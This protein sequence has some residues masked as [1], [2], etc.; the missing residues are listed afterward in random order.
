MSDGFFQY[1][2]SETSVDDSAYEDFLVA[3]RDGLGH[4]KSKIDE[5]LDGADE[6]TFDSERVVT[7]FVGIRIAEQ[8]PGA[9]GRGKSGALALLGCACL[10][11][12]PLALIGLGEWKAFELLGGQ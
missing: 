8:D 5:I 7:D 2:Y 11:L 4:L 9:M 1:G 3:D 6:V 12:I 10:A